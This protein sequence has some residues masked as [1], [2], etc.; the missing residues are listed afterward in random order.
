MAEKLLTDRRNPIEQ[1][2]LRDLTF[3]HY[4]LQVQ[5]K[6]SGFRSDVISEEID[7]MDDRV[8]DEA[9]QE[10]VPENGDRGLMDSE[11]S[12]AEGHCGIQAKEEPIEDA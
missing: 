8:V 12:E 11:C 6:R 10:V 1:Q 9:P 2:R 4:N 3:V 5:N 7:P